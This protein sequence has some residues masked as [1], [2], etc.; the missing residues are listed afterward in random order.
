MTPEELEHA[1]KLAIEA[2]A[3]LEKAFE[4]RK[5]PEA[6]GKELRTIEFVLNT[7]VEHLE[8]VRIEAMRRAG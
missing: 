2:R 5:D 8:A 7:L 6:F 4:E 3:H 1:Y